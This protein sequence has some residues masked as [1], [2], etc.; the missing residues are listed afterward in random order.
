MLCFKAVGLFAQSFEFNK[1]VYTSIKGAP[2][3][4]QPVLLTTEN[5]E[6]ISIEKLGQAAPALYDWDGDGKLDLLVGDFAKGLKSNI[7]VFL[8]KGHRRKP[9][10][11]DTCFLATDCTGEPLRIEGD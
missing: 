3:F 4:A 11:S 6:P 9:R 5:G 8:N 2:H 10:L 7:S 1:V